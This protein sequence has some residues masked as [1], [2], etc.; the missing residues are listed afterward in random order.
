MTDSTTMQ[1]ATLSCQHAA[2]VHAGVSV[3]DKVP[4]LKCKPAKTGGQAAQRTVKKLRD[5]D[6]QPSTDGPADAVDPPVDLAKARMDRLERAKKAAANGGD[7]AAVLAE[8]LPEAPKTRRSST[9]QGSGR[10]TFFHLSAAR[11]A[12]LRLAGMDI[13][14]DAK[15]VDV[16]PDQVQPLLAKLPDVVDDESRPQAVRTAA[17][18]AAVWLEKFRTEV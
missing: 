12:A 5:S 7:A 2:A 3:G 14:D 13:A 17:R 11:T 18:K 8:P 16:M 10:A 15:T 9:R 6:D 1:I 4:C